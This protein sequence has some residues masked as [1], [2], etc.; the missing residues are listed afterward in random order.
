MIFNI[1]FATIISLSVLLVLL[2]SLSCST[3]SQEN[4][5]QLP[6]IEQAISH[7]DRWAGDRDADSYRMPARILSFADVTQGMNIVDLLGGSGY[8]TE[9]LSYIVGEKG[10]I[11]IQNNSLFLE[12]NGEKLA[13]RLNNSRLKNVEQLDSE[14]DDM[15]LPTNVDVIFIALG[16]HDIHVPRSNPKHMTSPAP[17]LKQ[18]YR[19]LKP[20]G[21]LIIIDHAAKPNTGIQTTA[22]L[23]RIDEQYVMQEI[24]SAGFKFHGSSDALRN[25]TDNYE[26]DI[27]NKEVFHNT[28]RFVHLYIKQ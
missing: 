6:V 27:W 3:P 10:K 17:F 25:N 22:K 11:Y 19:S 5:Q 7:A 15:K 4:F 9:L 2:S 18:I 24:T 28:D 12:Y 21:K 26:L 23:H 8:Y 14:F 13:K 20:K 16:Y 1:K